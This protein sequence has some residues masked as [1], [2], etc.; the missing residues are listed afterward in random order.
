MVAF[1]ERQ[2]S[3]NCLCPKVHKLSMTNLFHVEVDAFE[4]IASSLVL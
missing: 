3:Y 1:L 4:V 2:P